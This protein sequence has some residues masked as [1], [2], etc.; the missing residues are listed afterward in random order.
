MSVDT[1]VKIFVDNVFATELVSSWSS[2]GYSEVIVNNPTVINCSNNTYLP[3]INDIW[4][5]TNIISNKKVI[6][7]FDSQNTSIF[8][9]S[10]QGVVKWVQKI[11]NTPESE[12]MIAIL[13]SNPK[14]FVV[15]SNIKPTIDKE[16]GA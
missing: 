11:P 3:E 8:A 10:V 16:S 12:M 2:D 6:N 7:S 14:F 1:V 15:R 9:Y 4:N 13:S 5:G